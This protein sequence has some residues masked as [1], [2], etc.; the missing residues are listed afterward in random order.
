VRRPDWTGADSVDAEPL[1]LFGTIDPAGVSDGPWA[2]LCPTGPSVLVRPTTATRT[3]SPTNRPAG[4]ARLIFVDLDDVP[5]DALGNRK[6]FPR[7]QIVCSFFR[8]PQGHL[9]SRP[10]N[11]ESGLR[12]KKRS[13]VHVHSR[14]LEACV[15]GHPFP[16]AQGLRRPGRDLGHKR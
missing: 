8:L 11:A 13:S 1:A 3:A 9:L 7:W 6:A 16:Q 5:G 2:A 15:D 4:E 14:G 12:A 10:A